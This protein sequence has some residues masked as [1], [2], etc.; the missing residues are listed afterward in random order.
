METSSA[1][2][3]GDC[4]VQYFIVIS[5]NYM[6]VIFG[7]FLDSVFILGKERELSRVRKT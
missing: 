6:C 4:K 7:N 2:P 1:T 3:W 5:R